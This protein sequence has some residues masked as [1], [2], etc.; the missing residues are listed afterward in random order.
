[1][2]A[3]EFDDLG[4]SLQG[5]TAASTA[6]E[7]MAHRVDWNTQS[8][9]KDLTHNPLLVIGA[10]KAG[11]AENRKLAEAV[12][13]AG[14]NV[15]AITIDSDHGFQDHRIALAGDVVSWLQKLPTK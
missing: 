8:W 5:A 4:N 7:V 12:R 3:K 1:L 11:G 6:A 10:A 14:G 15:T 9:A 2:I 13:A